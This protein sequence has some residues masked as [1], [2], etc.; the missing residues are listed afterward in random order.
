MG[1]AMIA[2]FFTVLAIL[3]N[4]TLLFEAFQLKGLKGGSAAQA[5]LGFFML[6]TT[7]GS[8]AM[9]ISVLILAI[10]Y[11]VNIKTIKINTT[12]LKRPIVLV[13]LA[14][15]ACPLLLGIYF[16]TGWLGHS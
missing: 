5:D 4:L 16:Y 12:L 11:L 2:W 8:G 3:A 14:N 7:L 1:A 13:C 6:L 10:G 15:I 9:I